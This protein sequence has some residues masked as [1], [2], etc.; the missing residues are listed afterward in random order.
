MPTLQAANWPHLTNF[1][2]ATGLQRGYRMQRTEYIQANMMHLAD[3]LD[4]TSDDSC[5]DQLRTLQQVL[6]NIYTAVL[7]PHGHTYLLHTTAAKTKF[8]KRMPLTLT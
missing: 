5:C 8:N 7:S 4:L 2:E 1:K 3:L 6:N